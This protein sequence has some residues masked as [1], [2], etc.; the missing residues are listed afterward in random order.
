[1][2][3]THIKFW[4]ENLERDQGLDERII[5]KLMLK[6]YDAVVWAG[7]IWPRITTGGGL[8]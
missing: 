1:V 8:L 6:K 5:L 2:R 7:F 4:W 3:D